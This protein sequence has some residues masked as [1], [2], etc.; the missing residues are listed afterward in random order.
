MHAAV[1]S[2]LDTVSCWKGLSYSQ[3]SELMVWYHIFSDCLTC[4]VEEAL[5]DALVDELLDSQ[6]KHYQELRFQNACGMRVTVQ[7]WVVSSSMS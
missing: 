7:D 1:T 6:G 3:A 4:L 5:K 2:H